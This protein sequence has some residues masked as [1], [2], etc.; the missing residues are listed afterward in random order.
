MCMKSIQVNNLTMISVIYEE[1]PVP[2]TLVFRI[3]NFLYCLF[4]FDSS[5]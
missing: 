4:Y 2:V 1:F 5:E 3:E